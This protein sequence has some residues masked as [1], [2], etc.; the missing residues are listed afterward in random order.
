MQ[1]LLGIFADFFRYVVRSSQI[2]RQRVV[3]LLH[4]P[5]QR[6]STT[7][8]GKMRNNSLPHGGRRRG[9]A[10]TFHLQFTFH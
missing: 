9:I 6:E 1:N 10:A 5:L 2:P 8:R 3:L 7:S 4:Y